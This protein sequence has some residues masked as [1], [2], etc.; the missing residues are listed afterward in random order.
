MKALETNAPARNRAMFKLPDDMGKRIKKTKKGEGYKGARHEDSTV[1][2][3]VGCTD[4]R[5]EAIAFYRGL[6]EK[7]PDVYGG[8]LANLMIG[9]AGLQFDGSVEA[10][11]RRGWIVGMAFALEGWFYEAACKREAQEPEANEMKRLDA[12][13]ISVDEF[14]C[15]AALLDGAIELLRDSESEKEISAWRL[16]DIA[17]YRLDQSAK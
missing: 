2:Y 8:R 7:H 16:L 13:E 15:I 6:M 12:L 14:C 4:G 10:G 1:A 3:G 17:K 11:Y 5:E 9:A